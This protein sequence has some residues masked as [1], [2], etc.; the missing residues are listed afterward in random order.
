MRVVWKRNW[1]SCIGCTVPTGRFAQNARPLSDDPPFAMPI[2]D[3]SPRCACDEIDKS[4]KEMTR[5]KSRYL[6]SL[7]HDNV[8]ERTVHLERPK[9]PPSGGIDEVQARQ[10]RPEGDNLAIGGKEPSANA[11]NLL[12]PHVSELA[13][14]CGRLP[15]VVVCLQSA[16]FLHGL[17]DEAP[18]RLWFA[19]PQGSGLVRK[20][21]PAWHMVHWS[22][23]D[24]FKV[25]IVADD[26]F[27][28]PIRRT[29]FPR[30]VIDLVRYTRYLHGPQPGI[31]AARRYVA[32]GGNV[33]DL[34]AM[35]GL[36]RVPAGTMRKLKM[37]AAALHDD[38]P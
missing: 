3:P 14:A 10:L 26:R 31:K 34:I 24:A 15:R 5:L 16:A 30:T 35:A 12:G 6:S 13:A 8:V 4:P 20:A 37:L 36:L 19:V 28:P 38:A 2:E 25:G 1:R 11:R 9:T 17:L 18:A 22:N 29:G 32:G 23:A 27:G 7:R 33:S 21:E